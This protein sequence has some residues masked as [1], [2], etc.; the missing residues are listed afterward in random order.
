MKKLFLLLMVLF[1]V[2]CVSSEVISQFSS[3]DDFKGKPSMILFASTTCPHCVDSVPVLRDDIY[4]DYKNDTNIWINVVNKRRFVTDV[5]QGFNKR[6]DFQEIT[7][8]ECNYVPSWLIL[9]ENGNL[10][11]SSC[12]SQKD[13]K[14]VKEILNE[15]VE[16]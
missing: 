1:L 5:P 10:V 12:G 9:D 14:I 6:L 13:L 2:G 7:G 15:L 11:D 3:L 16:N 4:L 8:Q